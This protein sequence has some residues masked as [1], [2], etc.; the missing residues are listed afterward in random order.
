MENQVPRD[1][2]LILCQKNNNLF[3]SQYQVLLK[4]SEVFLFVWLDLKIN[5]IYLFCLVG[6]FCEVCLV[7]SSLLQT[8][9]VSS[10]H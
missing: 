9:P 7:S 10:R 8:N 5:K 4:E 6:K 1:D 3:F 2:L